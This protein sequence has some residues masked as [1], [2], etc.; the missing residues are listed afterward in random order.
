MNCER[1]EHPEKKHCP[2]KIVHVGSYKGNREYV[3]TCVGRHC[4]NPL[5]SCVDFVEPAE[6][7]SK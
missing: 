7:V 6:A 4:L 1:C 2:G 3:V 5:C